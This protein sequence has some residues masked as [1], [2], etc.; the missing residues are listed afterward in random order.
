M[1]K[2]LSYIYPITNAITSEHNGILEIT[3][4]DGKKYLNTKNTNYSYGSLQT[5][6]KFGL[7]Q[8]DFHKVHSILLLG[9]GGGCVIETLREDF[10]YKKAIT[11]VDIDPKIIE[12][13]ALEFNIQN[14]EQLKI[15]CAD[16]FQFMKENTQPFDLIIVDLFVDVN[17]P[18]QFLEIPFWEYVMKALSSHG[19]ILFNAALEKPN[20][21]TFQDIV[22][23]L[24]RNA[25]HVNAFEKVNKT[26]SLVLAKR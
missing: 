15:V 11:A 6:L 7:E 1:K 26:N 22:G 20:S 10:N 9:L 16:A 5:I 17:V 4:H 25:F 18:E 8:I 24:I 21:N 19:T 23:F 2:L 3:W 13:A 12:I 14:N